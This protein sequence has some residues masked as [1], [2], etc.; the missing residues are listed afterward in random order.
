MCL[1]HML[2]SDQTLMVFSIIYKPCLKGSN[3]LTCFLVC[4]STGSTTMGRSFAFCASTGSTTMGRSF[5]FNC[6]S[7]ALP[8]SQWVDEQQSVNGL[9]TK[10]PH[11]ESNHSQK[12]SYT[13]Y[14]LAIRHCQRLSSSTQILE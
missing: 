5:V 12:H 2:T 3:Q 14:L 11:A 7:T 1:N 10:N 4:A 8:Q 6:A 13:C 9:A